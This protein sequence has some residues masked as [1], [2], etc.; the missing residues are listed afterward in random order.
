[1]FKKFDPRALL[2]QLK[3]RLPRSMV[4]RTYVVLDALPLNASGKVDR[5]SL[6]QAE[7]AAARGQSVGNVPPVGRTPLP[8]LPARLQRQQR[9]LKTPLL[10]AKQRKAMLMPR[11]LTPMLR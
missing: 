2:A 1:M 7:S 10:P 11:L 6:P 4:P 9:C 5:A 3:D 8:G